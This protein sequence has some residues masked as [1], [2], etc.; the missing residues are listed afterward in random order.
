MTTIAANLKMMA[1]DSRVVLGSTFY[2][3]DKIFRIGKSIVGV[4]GDAALTTKFLAWFRKEC[5]ADEIGM[6]LDEDH[7]FNGLVLNADGLYVY[8]DCT[9]PD[10]LREKCFAIGVG[11][12][13]A[14]A[15]M[16]MGKTPAE[17][18]KL[19]CELSPMTSGPPVKELWLHPPGTMPRRR[20]R[21]LIKTANDNQ[22]VEHGNS[23]N[24]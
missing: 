19:A 20:R 22:G 15:A 21:P 24:Q 13:I 3:T 8:G 6:M 16:K 1:G 9:E 2:S 5:P 4:A 10:L 7:S 11:A 14:L 23:Q 18:V 17:A 12:D